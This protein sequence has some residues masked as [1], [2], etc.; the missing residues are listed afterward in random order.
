MATKKKKAA[1]KAAPMTKSQLINALVEANEMSRKQIKEV[2]DAGTNPAMTEAM[3]VDPSGFSHTDSLEC[4]AC[5]SSWVPNCFGCHFERDEREMGLNLMTREYE[6]GK[7]TTNNKIFETMRHFALGPNSEGRVA[8]YLVAC[9]PIADVTAPD[10]SKLLDFVMPGSTIATRI[11]NG[12]SSSANCS[13]RPS[14][15]HLAATYGA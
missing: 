7:A 9:Q 11:P 2:L 15:A 12:E 5:H 13:L 3:G 10:G 14:S 8:P 1:A 6:V 4:Y